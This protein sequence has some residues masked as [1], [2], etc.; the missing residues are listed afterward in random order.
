M[1]ARRIMQR[2]LDR[3]FEKFD[4]LISPGVSFV[5]TPLD[6]DLEQAF[7]GPDPL[8]AA[9][10]LA[11]IPALTVPCGFTTANLPVGMQ[12]LGRPLEERR[13]LALGRLFQQK[14]EW[15]K[16]RPPAASPA[17]SGQ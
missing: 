3:V 15:H 13:I 5:A 11:G 2:E 8:G 9:G 14:T 1:Q 4:V 12:I 6:A 17:P 16:R 10:N 7:S